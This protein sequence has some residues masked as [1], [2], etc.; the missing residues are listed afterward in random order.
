M[1]TEPIVLLQGDLS[2][3]D[4]ADLSELTEALMT[5]LDENRTHDFSIGIT[6]FYGKLNHPGLASQLRPYILDASKNAISRRTAT[7]IAERCRLTALQAELLALAIDHGADPYLRGRA[8][9]TLS[10]CGDDTVPPRLLPFANGEMGPDPQDD[11]KGYALRILWPRHM[12]ARELFALITP[13][14]SGYVGAY[15]MFLTRTLPETL[16]VADLPIALKWAKSFV[17][18]TGHQGDFHRR[19][20]ADSVFVRSWRELDNGAVIGPLLD[21]VFARLRP[22][23]ALFGGTGLREAERFHGELEADVD[24]RRRFLFAAT[25]RRLDRMDAHHLMRAQLLQRE[26]LQWLLSLRPG[27]SGHDAALDPESLCNMIGFVAVLDDPE[28]FKAVYDAAL[29]WPA[30]WQS[31][32]G[33]LEGIPLASEEARQLRNTHEMMKRFQESPPPVTP[34][35]SER[36]TDLLGLF[37]AGDWAAWWRLNRELT[38]T[39][40]S[41]HYGSDLD[42]SISGMPGWQ[43]ADASTRRRILDGACRYLVLAATS[44]PEWIGTTTLHFNDLAAFRALLLLREL[45]ERNYRAVA[46]E[47]W[48]KWAPAVVAVPKSSGS[49]RAK[50]QAEVVA[51]ALAAA[52]AEFVGAVQEIMQRERARTAAGATGQP[53]TPGSSF[54]VLRELEGCW[55]SESLKA[56]IFAELQDDANSEDQFTAILDVLLAA[57]SVPARDFAVARLDRPGQRYAMAAAVGLSVHCAAEAWPA[58]WKSVVGD[59]AFAGSFFL[60]IAQRYRFQASFFD[61]LGEDELAEIYVHLETIFPRA[62]DPAHASGEPHFVGPHELLADLRDR[63]P[64]WIAGRGTAAAVKALR[65]IIAKLPGQS[66][67]SFRLLEAERTMRM[68]TWAPLSPRDLFALLSSKNRVLVQSPEDLCELLVATLRV[69]EKDLHGEQ[70]PVR[71][72]WDRQAGGLTFRPVEEGAFSDNVRLFLRREL[73]ESGIVANREVEVARVPGAPVGRRT[74]I[75]IDALRRSPDGPFDIMTA[76]IETKGCWNGELFGALKDQLF[77]DYMVTLRAPVG[78]YLVG[79]FDKAKWDSGDRRR[80]QAP[81]QSLREVQSR[82]DG[83]AAAIPGGYLVRAIVVDCHAP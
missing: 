55:D 34:P 48:K 61:L 69:F 42:Y 57:K 54:F 49:E 30:L 39:P 15:V 56:G 22:M 40:T 17:E 8:I 38:L 79:W 26:D 63:I 59:P 81:D 83:Q 46:P 67:L 35:P 74:D 64:Q 11:L 33:V 24:R 4:E 23:H 20:L 32:R 36:I 51:D 53:Q 37:E 19:S 80:R 75:R 71:A 60:G 52:P 7:L 31:F 28:G 82:L 43:D 78:I 72:L 58:I 50:F 62:A 14:N 2:D 41:T 1:R 9:D 77:D 65:G 18:E 6:S 16:A 68:K 44:V 25:Q 27:A 45:D 47:I 3:W 5:A 13:P 76:V 10:T 29:D 70:N 73:V 66:W 12:S 21:Y